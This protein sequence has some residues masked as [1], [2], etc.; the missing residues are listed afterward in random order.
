[1]AS[2]SLGKDGKSDEPGGARLTSPEGV[3]NPCEAVDVRRQCADGQAAFLAFQAFGSIQEG[4][5][6]WQGSL[7]GGSL[8]Q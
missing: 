1:L 3:K 5:V 8:S 4:A 6:A 2:F 7:D